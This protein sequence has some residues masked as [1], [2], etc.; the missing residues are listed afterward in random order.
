VIPIRLFKYYQEYSLR[1]ILDF[2]FLGYQ[3]F[4][5]NIPDWAI[6]LKDDAAYNEIVGWASWT[7]EQ[8]D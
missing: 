2:K 3:N 7:A 4:G 8:R 5:D 6:F 1:F